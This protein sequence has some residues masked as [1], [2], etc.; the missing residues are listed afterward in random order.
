M[1]KLQ[2]KIMKD[3]GWKLLSLA[4]AIAL[5]FMVIN[6]EH[7]V[8][9]RIYTQTVTIENIDALT[10]QGLTILNKGQ[11]ENMKVSAKVK[12]QR[13]AL[14][15]LTQYKN[16]I[17]AVVDF[18]KLENI[19]S[20]DTT[21]L[22]VSFLLPDSAGTG[23]EIV[24]QSPEKAEIMIEKL[25]AKRIPITVH[26]NGEAG[27]GYTTLQPQISPSSVQISGAASVVSRVKTVEVN[28]D[29]QQASEDIVVTAQ[30]VAYDENGKQVEGITIDVSK[31]HIS[32]GIQK[33][34]MVNLTAST[35]GV[36]E[37]GYEI[38]EI[39]WSPQ[40]INVAGSE[41]ILNSLQSITLP[42]VDVTGA[43]QTVVESFL[44]N[45]ILPDGI[46]LS[47]DTPLE[48]EVSVVIQQ[49]EEQQ[50][51]VQSA[52]IT[53]QGV[54]EEN[55]DYT[56][57]EKSVSL[58]LTGSARELAAIT[59]GSIAVTANVENLTEGEHDVALEITLPENI[60]LVGEVPSIVITIQQKQQQ[61]QPD[62]SQQPE[63]NE[64]ETNIDTDTDINTDIETEQTSISE[65]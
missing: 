36:P 50:I 55:Y 28:V 24:S 26:I 46:M 9:T 53:L 37:E 25:A 17:K 1:K 19:K 45:E 10:Q 35:K 49:Q 16:S 47:N 51:T 27:N 57:S 11:L 15:R 39:R 7:P 13:T 52:E 41:A 56:L 32:I 14:D 44:L 62:I 43:N 65:Q 48:A 54:E 42:A 22:D 59:T 21:S 64:N 4:I 58:Q 38:A 40:A 5:W 61:Q 33:N 20:G 23:F 8:T 63:Q 60:S 18:S 34:K 29:L 3:I 2:E 31:V 12:A 30:P 6:I